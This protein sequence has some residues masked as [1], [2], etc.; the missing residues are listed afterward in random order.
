MDHSR[1]PFRRPALAAAAVALGGVLLAGC[2]AVPVYGPGP[3]YGEPVPVAPPPPQAEVVGV[4]P[5]PGW[6][7]ISGYWGWQ[8]NRHVWIGGHWEAPRRGYRWNAPQWRQEGRAWRHA[9][10][11][12]SR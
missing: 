12:W 9:P 8:A 1:I 3:R 2:V 10:G 5:Y 6:I 11:Y 4:A 7:W